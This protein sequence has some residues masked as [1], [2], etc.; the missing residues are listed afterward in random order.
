MTDAQI[1]TLCDVIGQDYVFLDFVYQE[2]Y[3]FIN[4]L[5]NKDKWQI[6]YE[7]IN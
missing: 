7:L 4:D 1:K 2:K 5:L 3:M 6:H